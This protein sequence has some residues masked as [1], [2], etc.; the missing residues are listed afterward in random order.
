MIEDG[1]YF[2]SEH[3]LH[4]VNSKTV[5]WGTLAHDKVWGSAGVWL[6]ENSLEA[7]TPSALSW[8][9]AEAECFMGCTDG[10]LA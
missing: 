10:Q 6:V 9:E 1:L 5:A 4:I 2:V 3:A 7:Q 8:A